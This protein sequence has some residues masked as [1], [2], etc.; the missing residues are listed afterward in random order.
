MESKPVIV[1]TGGNGFIGQNLVDA[2]KQSGQATPVIVDY[3]DYLHPRNP[4][5]ESIMPQRLLEKLS[6]G[7]RPNA[8]IHLGACSSTTEK[9]PHK[10]LGNNLIYSI[11]LCNLARANNI[12]FIYAS[13]AAVY[14]NGGLFG[15]SDTHRDMYGLQP[16]NLYG[17][18]KLWFDQWVHQTYDFKGI[19]GL[20]FFNVY[21]YGER[22][23]G[24]MASIVT[25][26][27]QEIQKTGKITLYRD[28]DRAMERDFVHVSDC[29][30]VIAHFLRHHW[31]DGIFNCGSGRAET[32]ET[33]ANWMF[34]ELDK[35][36]QIEYK[37]LPEHIKAGYQYR[38]CAHLGKLYRK[39][40]YRHKFAPVNIGIAEYAGHLRRNGELCAE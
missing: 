10:V 18:S 12:R 1:V 20:R 9:N 4:D 6:S 30:W 21:G 28:E 34:A 27:F 22:H 29:L 25:R 36:P 15:F 26:G 32:W 39:G 38:T 33:V 37:E 35:E 8:I 5:V 13:S 2:I 40:R 17:W 23:K 3:I 19:V 31:I 7:F 11:E 14:G 24:S 16:N